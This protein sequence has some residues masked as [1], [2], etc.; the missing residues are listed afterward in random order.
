MA[1]F[2]LADFSGD[3]SAAG[4]VGVLSRGSLAVFGAAVLGLEGLC[5]DL[6][7]GVVVAVSAAG[8]FGVAFIAFIGDL[9]FA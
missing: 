6:N 5:I 2:G 8:F 4:L 3:L 9:D 1:D 7:L